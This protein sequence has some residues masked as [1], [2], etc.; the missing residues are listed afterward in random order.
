MGQSINLIPQEEI[1][2]QRKESLVKASS[3]FAVVVL[4]LTALVT[5]YY[6][7][8]RNN[9]KSSIA[10]KEIEIEGFRSD[11]KNFSEMEIVARTLDAKYQILTNIFETRRL[12]SVLFKELQAQLPEGVLMDSFSLSGDGNNT[13]NLAGTGSNY[14]SIARFLNTLTDNNPD[15]F[16][17]VQLNSVTLDNQNANVKYFITIDFNEEFLR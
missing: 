3:I 7:Y 5:G 15:L 6:L 8:T 4:I 1:V 14:L 12:Y 11:I 17:Q 13:I 16:T 9:I 2:E 10:Q